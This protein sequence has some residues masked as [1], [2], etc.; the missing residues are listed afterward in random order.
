[1]MQEDIFIIEMINYGKIEVKQT[2]SN[3]FRL[4]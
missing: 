1:M 3:L 4:C 2:F